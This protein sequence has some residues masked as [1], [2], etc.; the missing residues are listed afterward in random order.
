MI[1]DQLCVD[2]ENLVQHIFKSRIKGG[3]GDIA[4]CKQLQGFQFSG[5]AS[6]YTPEICQRTVCPQ[7]FPV[8]HFIEFG[9]ADAILVRLSFLGNNIHGHLGEIQI[10][11]DACGRCNSRIV[12]HITHHGHGEFMR[13]HTVRLQIVRH[14]DEHFINGVDD[15]ILGSNI[16]EVGRIDSA[17]VFLVQSHARRCDYIR[18][19]KRRIVV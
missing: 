17:A 9:D 15:N 5:S 19:L 11:A 12:Q 4:H 13:R 14:I 6:A 7:Q 8:F 18:N 1:N 10:G 16:F 3:P 2:A